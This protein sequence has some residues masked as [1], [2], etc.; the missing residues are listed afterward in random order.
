LLR[1]ALLAQAITVCFTFTTALEVASSESGICQEAGGEAQ[2]MGENE[3]YLPSN[4][5][6]WGGKMGK[7][8]GLML[9]VN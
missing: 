2:Q 3:A 9:L 6:L 8:G 5:L 4:R 1:A 7:I